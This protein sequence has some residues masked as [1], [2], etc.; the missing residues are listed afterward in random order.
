VMRCRVGTGEVVKSGKFP[1]VVSRKGVGANSIKCTSCNSWI[2]TNAVASVESLPNVSNFHCT[3]LSEK[4]KEISL[5]AESADLQLKCI[6]KFCY[7]GD[8]VGAGGGAEDSS[9][10]RAMR[11]AW[12][13]FRE[14]APILT[15]R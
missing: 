4:L 8:V 15:S 3:N 13:K 11:S 10:A 5:G 6:G 14:L 1:C 7:F 2:H 9:R 12:S